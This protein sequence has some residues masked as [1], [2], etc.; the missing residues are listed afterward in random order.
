MNY[1]F[2][3][4]CE[5]I[6]INLSFSWWH[7]FFTRIIAIIQKIS[8]NNAEIIIGYLY[9]VKVNFNICFKYD[10]IMFRKHHIVTYKRVNNKISGIDAVES[11]LHIS[12]RCINII[13]NFTVVLF[14]QTFP[15]EKIMLFNIVDNLA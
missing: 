11:L 7:Y 13:I 2:T 3:L 4:C 8:E 5:N 9:I 15:D 6:N 14:V 10:I 12:D 1:K